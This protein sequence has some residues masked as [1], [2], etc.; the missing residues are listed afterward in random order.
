MNSK[1]YVYVV[2]GA[3]ADDRKSNPFGHDCFWVVAIA[4]TPRDATLMIIKDLLHRY[5][6][7][8]NLNDSDREKYKKYLVD[9]EF[10]LRK[11]GL[12]TQKQLV[13]DTIDELVADS[14]YM[15]TCD[16]FVYKISKQAL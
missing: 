6:V 4:P 11:M 16:S 2:I 3:D 8:F 10:E 15:Y 13:H 9:G 5:S 1:K 7:V 14:E 12:F